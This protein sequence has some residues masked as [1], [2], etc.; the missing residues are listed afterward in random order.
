[1]A[2]DDRARERRFRA[3]LAEARSW[4]Q[5]HEVVFVCG[6]PRSGTTMLVRTLARHEAFRTDVRFIETRVFTVRSGLAAR[7]ADPTSRQARFLGAHHVEAA[8][9]LAWMERRSLRGKLPWWG[10][11]ARDE[12]ATVYLWHAWHARGVQRLLEKS[13]QHVTHLDRVLRTF[14]RGRVVVIARHPVDVYA[15]YRTRLARSLEQG[16]AP[17]DLGWLRLGPEELA[18]RW[19]VATESALRALADEP[20]RVRLVHYDALT[21]DAER[22]LRELCAFLEIEWDDAL[23]ASEE[24]LGGPRFGRQSPRG[25]ISANPSRWRDVLTEEEARAVESG[26]VDGRDRLGFPSL[27]DDGG[28]R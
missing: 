10:V 19:S 21:N 17:E 24:H 16:R 12:L 1:M 6:M 5:D 8:E 26:T 3:D 22:S 13:P 11:R 28:A 2:T 9:H 14:P 4:A 18:S 23:L 27:V 25:S 7:T 20:A 15:S